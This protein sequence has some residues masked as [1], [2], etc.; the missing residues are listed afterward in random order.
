MGLF[1]KKEQ[2][3]TIEPTV[4]TE[5]QQVAAM[6]AIEPTQNAD[7]VF[8]SG[9]SQNVE[10]QPIE[11][12][13]AEMQIQNVNEV[14]ADTAAVVDTPNPQVE[15]QVAIGVNAE[16]IFEGGQPIADEITRLVTEVV[17][18][19]LMPGQTPVD[20][21]PPAAIPQVTVEPAPVVEAQPVTEVAPIVEP[22]P[23]VE[24]VA[25]VVEEPFNENEIDEEI[26]SILSSTS[27]QNVMEEDDDDNQP[28]D[29]DAMFEKTESKPEQ[30][31]TTDNKS[32]NLTINSIF[33]VDDTETDSNDN[34][35]DDFEK[36]INDL[37]NKEA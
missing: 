15:Q 14:A 17:Q 16:E 3:A 23:A 9:A 33:N 22:T 11:V 34:L 21:I 4:G 13:I 18:Q 26:D 5:V 1:D 8:T 10:P 12:S 30:E 27:I 31:K 32:K 36:Y 24:E 6:P 29:I 28:L 19:E 20:P 37:G 25:P 7:N 35:A 2:T